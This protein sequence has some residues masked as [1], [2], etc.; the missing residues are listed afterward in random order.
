MYMYSSHQY[1]YIIIAS[2][3]FNL[4]IGYANIQCCYAVMNN[5]C[6]VQKF[7]MTSICNQSTQVLL[8][9]ING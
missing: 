8:I 1:M 7:A 4:N 5:A 9:K 2:V 3:E 6:I